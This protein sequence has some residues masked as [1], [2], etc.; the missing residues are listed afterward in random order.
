MNKENL[1]ADESDFTDD[2]VLLTEEQLQE[3]RRRLAEHRRDPSSAIPVEDFIKK[4]RER[5]E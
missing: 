1:E 3:L 2:D 4:M 5:F